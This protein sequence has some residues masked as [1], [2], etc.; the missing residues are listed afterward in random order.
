MQVNEEV[1][2]TIL[3]HGTK[4]TNLHHAVKAETHV[5]HFHTVPDTAV[6]SDS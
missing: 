1:K 3:H 2:K 6:C 4:R 5:L